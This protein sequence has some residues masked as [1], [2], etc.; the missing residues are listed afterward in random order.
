MLFPVAAPLMKDTGGWHVASK[1]LEYREKT[2]RWI[3]WHHKAEQPGRVDLYWKNE[4]D[5]ELQL[6][7]RALH[8]DGW[9]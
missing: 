1:H 5:L 8:R 9:A 2:S 4:F 6:V 7:E 3:W